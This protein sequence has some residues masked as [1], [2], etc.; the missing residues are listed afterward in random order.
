[1]DPVAFVI[2]DGVV[3]PP[4]EPLTDKDHVE[5]D[6]RVALVKNEVKV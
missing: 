6:G 1:M 5:G 2:P 3:V 4:A